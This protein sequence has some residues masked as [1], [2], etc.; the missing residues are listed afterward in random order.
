MSPRHRLES[1]H[2]VPDDALRR[3]ERICSSVPRLRAASTGAVCSRSE[4]GRAF[5]VGQGDHRCGDSCCCS[6][7]RPAVEALVEAEPAPGG[8]AMLLCS[9]R[10]AAIA[11]SRTR[12]TASSCGIVVGFET[13]KLRI[14]A[15]SSVM[16]GTLGKRFGSCKSSSSRYVGS[17][18]L[19]PRRTERTVAPNMYRSAFGER[20][21][22][23]RGHRGA[24]SL[25]T[26]RVVVSSPSSSR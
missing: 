5:V 10:P 24:Q 19:Y 8:V 26:G 3:A 11:S 22:S 13:N 14:T 16:P 20:A 23:S 4:G 9:R 18:G 15:S 21:S 6:R 7:R 25:L 1:P 12:P 17:S 2:A